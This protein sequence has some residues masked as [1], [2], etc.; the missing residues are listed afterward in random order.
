MGERA[1]RSRLAFVHSDHAASECYAPTL[2]LDHP[3]G[4]A[5]DAT[6]LAMPAARSVLRRRRNQLVAAVVMVDDGAR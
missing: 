3:S 2:N 5:R 6:E 1:G 4:Q